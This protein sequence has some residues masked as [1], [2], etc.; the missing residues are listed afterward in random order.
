[1]T[2]SKMDEFD[3]YITLNKPRKITDGSDD[4]NE[5]KEEIKVQ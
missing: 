2:V 1:M 5:V 3:D 4:E